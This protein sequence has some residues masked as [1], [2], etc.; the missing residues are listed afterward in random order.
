MHGLL[1]RIRRRTTRLR[2]LRV[3]GRKME[4]R[5]RLET[6][7]RLLL[8]LMDPRRLH[9]RCRVGVWARDRGVHVHVLRQSEGIGLLAEARPGLILL[10][11]LEGKGLSRQ[12][13]VGS[14]MRR[15]R[16]RGEQLLRVCVRDRA[17]M[18]LVEVVRMSV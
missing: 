9:S 13:R 14:S 16:C 10:Q 6:S 8:V 3:R 4:S 12:S 15:E 7:A 17:R 1:L 5:I 2:R 18:V 11:L